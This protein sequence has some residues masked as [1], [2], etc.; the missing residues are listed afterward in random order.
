MNTR[1]GSVID[2][3]A[4]VLETLSPDYMVPGIALPLLLPT[5]I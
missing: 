2:E 5:L 1:G 4:R 3:H